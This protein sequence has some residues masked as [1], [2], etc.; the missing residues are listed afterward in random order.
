MH[1]LGSGKS[2]KWHRVCNRVGELFAKFMP[3]SVAACAQC[4]QAR[5]E[6]SHLGP[7]D[8]F[9]SFLWGEQ[10]EFSSEDPASIVVASQT[11]VRLL[12]AIEGNRH[13]SLGVASQVHFGSN[14][15]TGA[16][17]A[18]VRAIR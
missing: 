3:P 10:K 18:A 16:G 2:A 8:G 1:S 14:A 7:R 13:F 4:K 17:D 9:V 6:S 15:P 12:A 5:G 11:E